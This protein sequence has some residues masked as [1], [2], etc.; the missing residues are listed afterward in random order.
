MAK[1]K[2]NQRVVLTS[3]LTNCKHG[4]VLSIEV[5]YVVQQDDGLILKYDGGKL[6]PVS[7]EVSHE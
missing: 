5:R 1:F 3:S 2:I 6:K 4:K 7:I